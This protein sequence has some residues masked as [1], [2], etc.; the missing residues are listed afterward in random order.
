MK[1]VKM[2]CGAALLG[3][4]LNLN[5]AFAAD[6]TNAAVVATPLATNAPA[7]G[8]RR[9]GPP[10]PPATAEDIAQMAKL[11]DLPPYATGLGDGDYSVGPKYTPAPEES[12]R[13]GIPHG[14]TIQFT[15]DSAGS[16]FY[17]GTDAGFK[18][19][20]AVYVPAQYVPGT[21]APVI[22]SCDRYGL[23]PRTGLVKN[24]LDNMIADKRLPVM[25]V[26]MVAPGG[27]ERSVEYDT[28]SGKYAEFV[29]AEVLPRAEKEAGVTITKDPAGRMAYGGSSG[30]VAAFTMAWFHPELYHR[31]LSYSGTYVN[32]QH[33]DAVPH[34]AWEYNEHLIPNSPAKPLRVWMEVAQNDNGATTASSAYRNWVIA[35]QNMAAALKAKG[36][37]YQLVYA[38]NAGHTD[39][40]VN[41]QTFPQAL[42]YL[43][44]D[45]QPVTK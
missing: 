31:V 18:R 14:K 13:E 32:L 29:E 33:S 37:H 2:T 1:I 6:P 25:I 12:P 24:T 5:P 16:K 15:M 30:G 40:N 8:G 10:G 34:G 4:T 23:S 19:E 44:R 43:W 26:V 21:P 9:G 39:G 3:V 7:G 41:A 17:P 42:E 22:V 36:Y 11:N 27:P 28:V 20:V 35:N 45:Y 38:R